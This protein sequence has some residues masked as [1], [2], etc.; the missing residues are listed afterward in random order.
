MQ[1]VLNSTLGTVGFIG[2]A[3]S[4]NPEGALGEW[5]EILNTLE[6]LIQDFESLRDFCEPLC[7]KISSSFILFLVGHLCSIINCQLSFPRIFTV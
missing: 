3:L 2:R 4:G 6:M 1:G 7:L 5:S